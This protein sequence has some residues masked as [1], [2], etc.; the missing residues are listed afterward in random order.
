MCPDMTHSQM[1]RVAPTDPWDALQSVG[2]LWIPYVPYIVAKTRNNRPI[3]CLTEEA[4]TD[5]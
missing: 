5:P 1:Y 3:G 2:A 4:T